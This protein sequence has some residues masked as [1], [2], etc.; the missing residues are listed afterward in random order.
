MKLLSAPKEKNFNLRTQKGFTLV[1]IVVVMAILGIL[2]TITLVA[3]NPLESLAKARDIGKIT[4]VNALSKGILTYESRV[5]S[6][7]VP[8]A[9]WISDLKAG[10]DIAGNVVF[11]S[12]PLSPSSVCTTNNETGYCF[13]SSGGNLIVYT[14]VESTGNLQKACGSTPGPSDIAWVIWSSADSRQGLYCGTS[15]DPAPQEFGGL[16]K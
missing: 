13:A 12:G 1:E 3:L 6:A 15:A 7:P 4:A 16:L 8:S 9:T 2:M 11:P 10:G 14:R 5:S